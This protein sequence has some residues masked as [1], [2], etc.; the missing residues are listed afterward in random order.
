MHFC[1]NSGDLN[2]LQVTS[3]K[4][5]QQYWVRR[6]EPYR[7]ITSKEFSEAYQAFHVGRKLGNDLAVS[8]DKRKSHPAAL[9]TEKYGIGK[10]QLFEVCKEREYL[11]MKRNSFVYIFKF[12]QVNYLVYYKY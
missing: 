6:D 12:C 2:F 11:L 8:F 4:D 3:K 7:F 9:T 1:S 5:Q 10:K